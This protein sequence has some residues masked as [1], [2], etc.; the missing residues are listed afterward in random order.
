[1]ADNFQT[2][3]LIVTVLGIVLSVFSMIFIFLGK[4]IQGASGKQQLSYK[5]LELRTDAVILLICISVSAA[6][7]PLYF[8]YSLHLKNDPAEI[9][10]L[11]GQL[12]E[13]E[14]GQTRFTVNGYVTDGVSRQPLEGA[15][16]RVVRI[17]VIPP[18]DVTTIGPTDNQGSYGQALAFEGPGDQLRLV[19][20]KDGY[21]S[22]EIVISRNW[23][24]FPPVLSKKK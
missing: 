14:E 7:I 17:T 6:I 2:L 15:R 13:A 8:Q 22:Q 10:R 9:A 16:I 5:G 23:V 19:A 21:S 18:K 1:M 3:S 20:E 11:K 4:R 12:K 24:T